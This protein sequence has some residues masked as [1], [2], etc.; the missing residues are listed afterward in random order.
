MGILTFLP[1]LV[2]LALNVR[3]IYELRRSSRY[4]QYYMG[5]DYRNR[6]VVSSEEMKITLMLIGVV[7]AFFLCHVP[8]MIY[9]Y[10]RHNLDT[11]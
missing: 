9:R 7:V 8:Y 1:L 4:L 3:I 6:S 11:L 5:T 10:I 2:L